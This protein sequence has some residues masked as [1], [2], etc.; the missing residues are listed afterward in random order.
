MAGYPIVG[1]FDGDGMDDLGART[2]DVFSLELEQPG[3]DRR[4]DRH[5]IQSRP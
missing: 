4:R 5:A 1:D 2:D 3:T